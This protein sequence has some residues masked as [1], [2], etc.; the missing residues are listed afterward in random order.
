MTEADKAHFAAFARQHDANI[1]L[2]PGGEDSVSGLNHNNVIQYVI[3]IET[4]ND[5]QA[6]VQHRR[7]LMDFLPYH[8]TQ[9]NFAMNQKMLKQALDWLDLQPHD[10]VLDLFCG[11]GNFTLPIAQRVRHVVGVEGAKALLDWGK[12]N[13]KNNGIDNAGFYQADLTQDTSLMAWRVKYDYNKVLIDPPRSGALEIMPLIHA[14]SPEKICYVSCHPATLARDIDK[15]VN[16]YGYRLLTGSV[17]LMVSVSLI[18]YTSA[19]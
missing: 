14:L 15:L 3:D 1:Y 16:Q 19:Q 10:Q 17:I 8:F 6:K 12:R 11:L 9:V 2:Q 5:K 18:I 7:L 13:A 4:E